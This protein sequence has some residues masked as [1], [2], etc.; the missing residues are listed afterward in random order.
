MARRST[1]CGC[2]QATGT[3]RRDLH[4]TW[5]SRAGTTLTLRRVSQEPDASSE[6][7]QC[8]GIS[9]HFTVEAPPY[10]LCKR[11]LFDT[12]QCPVVSGE[13]SWLMVMH[14][15]HSDGVRRPLG[16]HDAGSDVR[17]TTMSSIPYPPKA[18]RTYQS[19]N[20]HTF[21]QDSKNKRQ[22]QL[23]ASIVH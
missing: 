13:S 6:A 11:N 23:K 15:R 5:T 4:G 22:T 16:A 20:H 8:S 3:A 9:E 17:P 7:K 14:T 19:I 21:A 18:H 12:S 1:A 2:A 10:R